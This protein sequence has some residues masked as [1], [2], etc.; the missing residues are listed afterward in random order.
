MIEVGRRGGQIKMESWGEGRSWGG[1]FGGLES[2]AKGAI[3]CCCSA[4]R[5]V[6]VIFNGKQIFFYHTPNARHNVNVSKCAAAS[7]HANAIM[8]F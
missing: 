1:G 8:V 6:T 3:T 2:I 4:Y 5:K 7:Q